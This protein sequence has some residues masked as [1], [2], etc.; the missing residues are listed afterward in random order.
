MH[1]SPTLRAYTPYLWFAA[2]TL[3]WAH[4]CSGR[5]YFYGYRGLPYPL[6]LVCLQ[7]LRLVGWFAAFEWKSFRWVVVVYQICLS[8]HCLAHGFDS[9]FFQRRVL[10]Y[11]EIV[12]CNIFGSYRC[13]RLYHWWR[14]LFAWWLKRVSVVALPDL[15]SCLALISGNEA[16]CRFHGWSYDQWLQKSCYRYWCIHVHLLYWLTWLVRCL[17]QFHRRQ[18]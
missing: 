6:L 10:S 2:A 14:R 18:T 12:L 15:V 16:A 13:A 5:F 8:V 9:Q 4:R 3:W 1:S 11:C 17:F 7:S